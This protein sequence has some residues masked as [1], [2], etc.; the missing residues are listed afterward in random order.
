MSGSDWK[1]WNWL[2]RGVIPLL[3]ALMFAAWLRPIY[4]ALLN[5]SLVSPSGLHYPLWL[6]VLIPLAISTLQRA[7]QERGGSR[8]WTASLALLLI[9]AALV[10]LAPEGADFFRQPLNALREVLASLARFQG[11]LPAALLLLVLN[12]VLVLRGMTADWTSHDE[13][14]GSFVIGV[15]ALG[16]LMLL[17]PA[18]TAPLGL[19]RAMASFLL[20]G[21]LALAVIAVTNTLTSQR[22]LG[23]KAPTVSRHWLVVVGVSVGL[24]IAVGWALGLLFSPET[25]AEVMHWFDPLRRFVGRMFSWLLTAIVYL[26]FLVLEP[27]INWLASLI[28]K[29]EMPK[30][31]LVKPFAIELEEL[32]QEEAQTGAA[33]PWGA[34]AAGLIVLAIIISIILVWRRRQHVHTTGPVDE[35]REYIG[36]LDLFLSQLRDLLNISRRQRRALFLEELDGSDPRTRVRLLYRRLL[37]LGRSIEQP[38]M[39]EQ[40]P[41]AYARRLS[42]IRPSESADLQTLTQAYHLARYSD[43][44]LSAEQMAAAEQA[45]KRIEAAFNPDAR[46]AHAD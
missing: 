7:L 6:I 36:S 35:Q 27:L 13:L 15:L 16:V 9:V 38:R 24:V 4:Q 19:G 25:V 20:W 29:R 1:R 5:W 18:I 22:A 28:A 21:L 11:K 3:S 26:I 45:T 17:R 39:P 14:W 46:N 31:E 41:A 2:E 12:A 32:A 33:I 44:A 40:T 30:I 37:M 8:W 23:K 43:E 34:I 10:Y 42:R